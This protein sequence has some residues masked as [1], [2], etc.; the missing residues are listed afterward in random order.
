MHPLFLISK[1]W[2]VLFFH[3]YI[4]VVSIYIHREVGPTCSYLPTLPVFLGVSKF[5]MKSPG[6]LVRAPNLPRTT[7]CGPFYIS[8]SLILEVMYC[9]YIKKSEIQ[10]NRSANKTGPHFE[11]FR[12]CLQVFVLWGLAGMQQFR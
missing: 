6:L 4:F 10:K 11:N 7:Y 2:I 9:Y 12:G 1:P 3:C 8:Y 5:F